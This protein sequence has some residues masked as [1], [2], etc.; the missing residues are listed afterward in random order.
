M[1]STAAASQG[2]RV[3]ARGD[4][5]GGGAEVPDRDRLRG[6]SRHQIE[7]G[8]GD[9]DQRSLGPDDELGQV[10]RLTVA[11][12]AGR[13][14]THRP[15]ARTAGDRATIASRLRSTMPGSSR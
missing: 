4:R 12:P 13:A 2:D 15:D 7:L 5:L 9:H 6:R 10:K 3:G 11:E 14:G 8:L 1:S